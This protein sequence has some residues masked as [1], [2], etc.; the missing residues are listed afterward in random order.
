MAAS[1][2]RKRNGLSENTRARIQT[3]MIVMR[4]ENH[5]L[6]KIEMTATQ[7]RAAEILIRKTLPDLSSIDMNAIVQQVTDAS[8]LTD[9]E[10]AAIATASSTRA[11][12]KTEGKSIVH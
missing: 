12:S 1:H 8:K 5:I 2:A 10:L 6:G 7:V 9:S 11:D 3:T 4:L